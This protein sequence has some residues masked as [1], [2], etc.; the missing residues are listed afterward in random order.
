RGSELERELKRKRV[1]LDEKLSEA[2]AQE[3]A[4]KEQK[5]QLY[6]S[7][8]A[9]RSKLKASYAASISIAKEAAR[10]SDVKEIHK[11]M[12]EA[13]IALPKEEPLKRETGYLFKVGDSIKYRNS[14]GTVV[15][16]KANEAMIEVEGMRLRVRSDELRPSCNQPRKKTTTQVHH[17]IER[18][19][20]LKLD[21]HGLRA[22]EAEEKMDKFLSDALIDGWDEVL[23]YHGVGTG[24]LSYAVKN[25]LR[26]HPK[27]KSF[28]NAP[29]N[30]GGS[31]AKVVRL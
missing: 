11:K 7:F 9:E 14:K 3:R 26:A 20:S 23:I 8:E 13:N 16:L 1:V 12:N 18:R 4:I 19:G 5:E 21:I 2:E 24:R 27:V 30:M 15:S 28:D 29:H 10:L 25:F 17:K 6:A 31:G 22:D